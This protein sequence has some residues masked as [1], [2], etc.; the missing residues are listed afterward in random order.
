MLCK[1]P[2]MA[3]TVPFGCGQCLPCRINRARQWQWR[4]VLESL[5]HDENC[6]VTLTYSDDNLPRDGSLDPKALQLFL[7]RVREKIEPLRIRFFAVGEYGE[8]SLRPHYHLSLFGLSGFTVVHGHNA[9]FTGSQAIAASWPHGFVQVGEFTPASAGYLTGYVVKKLK[10]RTTGA[11]GDR[12]PEFARM[13]NRPGIGAASMLTIAKSLND[14]GIPFI[15]E[16][17]DIPHSLKIGRKNVPLPRYLIQKLREAIGF[18]DEYIAEI[19]AAGTM[20]KSLEMLALHMG[21]EEPK[22][23]KENYLQEVSQKI[24]NLV[25]RSQIYSS[26]KTL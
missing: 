15:E 13:S 26:R 7:K 20:E 23:P 25:K 4:Q 22:S 3:G 9:A 12:R 11:L 1:K 17:G 14:G 16:T 18:T 21:L 10:D 24:E 5:T 19:K 6:F 8:H 2:F